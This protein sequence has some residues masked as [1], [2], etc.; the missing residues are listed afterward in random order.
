M[1]GFALSELPPYGVCRVVAVGPSPIKTRLEGM[2]VTEGAEMV[3]LYSAPSGDPTAYSVRGTVV[4]IR[5]NDADLIR[6][7]G[8]GEWA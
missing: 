1:R 4:A 7:R 6:V 8:C 2:G 3:R 5:R